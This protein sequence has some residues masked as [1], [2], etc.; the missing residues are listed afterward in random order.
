VTRLQR[1]GAAIIALGGVMVSACGSI[2]GPSESLPGRDP[3]AAASIEVLTNQVVTPAPNFA[4]TCQTGA[5]VRLSGADSFDPTGRGLRYR[6]LDTVEGVPT[7][8]FGPGFNPYETGD[9]VSGVVLATLGAHVIEL[10]VTASDGGKAR[11]TLHVLVTT[12]G[13]CGG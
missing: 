8:D 1:I 4:A 6:W 13:S 5:I 12:C 2:G 3:I 9:A 7:P 11:T 10:T